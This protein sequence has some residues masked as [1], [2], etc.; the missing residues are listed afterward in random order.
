ME[1]SLPCSQNP[2]HTD[3]K[4]VL[5]KNQKLGNTPRLNTA[6]ESPSDCE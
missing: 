5:Q 3:G 4:H 6:D 2:K 1:V